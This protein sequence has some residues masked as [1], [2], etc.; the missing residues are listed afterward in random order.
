M[1]DAEPWLDPQFGQEG[2]RYGNVNDKEDQEFE[3]AKDTYRKAWNA[4]KQDPASA[5]KWFGEAANLFETCK[6]PN[7]AQKARSYS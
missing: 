2:I 5:K 4:R 1:N 6:A 3:K 7:L